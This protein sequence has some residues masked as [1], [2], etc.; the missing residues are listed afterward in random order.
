MEG[1]GRLR[2]RESL[3]RQEQPRRLRLQ[4]D[5]ELHDQPDRGI[6]DAALDPGDVGPIDLRLEGE[7]LL[8]EPEG[9]TATTDREAKSLQRSSRRGVKVHVRDVRPPWPGDPRT[10]S[11]IDLA[12]PV[13]GESQCGATAPR[14]E[15][16]PGS[17]ARRIC[18]A[19]EVD[20][21]AD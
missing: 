10:R 12:T 11:H 14:G 7:T 20:A 15:G 19:G 21:V 18:H 16:P 2:I 9:L 8:K 13:D 6:P 5:R 3:R 1:S 17:G 4:R